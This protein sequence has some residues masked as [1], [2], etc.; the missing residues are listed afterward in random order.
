MGAV[1]GKED[2]FLETTK[3]VKRLSKVAVQVPKATEVPIRSA[4]CADAVRPE[5]RQKR[6]KVAL[7]GGKLT[8]RMHYALAAAAQIG[9]TT[10]RSDACRFVNGMPGGAHWGSEALPRTLQGT[11]YKAFV[12][13]MAEVADVV[14]A[15]LRHRQVPTALVVTEVLS[16]FACDPGRSIGL[17]INKHL[18]SHFFAKG[19]EASQVLNAVLEEASSFYD[20]RECPDDG[21]TR[22]LKAYADYHGLA[23]H[24]WDGD[25]DLV[26]TVLL[27][28]QL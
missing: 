10:L 14:F 4:R 12:K 24:G 9:A 20:D 1:A 13:G 7:L 26:R 21:D 11:V 15:L 6:V 28:G 25:F 19:G 27:A 18:V 8:P 16:P 23:A 5:I 17:E 3:R 2:W 22:E